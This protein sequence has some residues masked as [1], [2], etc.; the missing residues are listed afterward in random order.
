VV[1]LCWPS[2]YQDKQSLAW[3]WS[4]L[5]WMRCVETK[6][7]ESPLK[8]FMQCCW[9][10]NRRRKGNLNYYSGVNSVIWHS[11]CNF[12]YVYFVFDVSIL[13]GDL[14][15]NLWSIALCQNN[16]YYEFSSW[17]VLV[18]EYSV[19]GTFRF[20]LFSYHGK[21]FVKLFDF[22]WEVWSSFCCCD[23]L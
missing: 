2:C 20:S 4:L 11:H 5:S 19:P 3:K 15:K 13:F 10:R 18:L 9:Y 21:L 6:K 14:L 8:V 16:R 7:T 1:W 12:D 23:Q 17:L 22:P